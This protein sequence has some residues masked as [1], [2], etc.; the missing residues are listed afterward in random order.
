MDTTDEQL[1]MNDCYFD[2]K[3]WRACRQEV[4]IL[5]AQ[6]HHD[7]LLCIEIPPMV[8]YSSCA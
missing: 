7:D 1:K 6:P 3:D 2:R 8:A 4:G 5:F